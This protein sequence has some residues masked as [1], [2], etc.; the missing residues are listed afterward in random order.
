MASVE[1]E[2][3]QPRRIEEDFVRAALRNYFCE[4]GCH[5]V[6]VATVD[7]LGADYVSVS[8]KSRYVVSPHNGG[9][10]CGPAFSLAVY[11]TDQLPGFHPLLPESKTTVIKYGCALMKVSV[12]EKRLHWHHLLKL[13][14]GRTP[15]LL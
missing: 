7:P 13:G 8:S 3:A 5:R 14:L 2:I 15:D 9:G 12:R 1:L 6:V 4:S 10:M 11:C